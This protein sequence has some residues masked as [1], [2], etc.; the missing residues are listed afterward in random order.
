MRKYAVSVIIVS[1]IALLGFLF[2]T[3]YFQ[4]VDSLIKPPKLEGE[5]LSIQLAFENSIDEDYVLK[6]PLSGEY[7]SA[8]IF[9][10]LTGDNDD[11]VIVFYSK[12]S[13]LGIVH[14]N[15]IDKTDGE[16]VSI[17]DF[18][19]VHNDIQEI[20]FADLNGDG[21]KEV[22]VGWTV[23]GE[24]YAKLLTIYQFSVEDK[25]MLSPIY[26][27]YYSKFDV[28]DINSDSNDDIISLK[29]T[30]AGNVAEYTAALSASSFEMLTRSG[31]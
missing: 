25:L 18:Q 8:Y 9:A 4:P 26:S 16:W 15:V 1:L 7:K 31:I 17:A 19:S 21:T 6:Q 11:E 3:T 22:I 5:N 28:S 24:S 23:L 12:S 10:D 20:N 27:D 30:T 13:E 14:M 29:H 2:I